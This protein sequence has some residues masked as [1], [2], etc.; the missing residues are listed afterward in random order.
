MI[1]IGTDFQGW[2]INAM[3]LREILKQ[4]GFKDEDGKMSIESK[5]PLLDSYPCILTDDGMGYGVDPQYV[6]EADTDIYDTQVKTLELVKND[7]SEL[8]YDEEVKTKTIKVFNVFRDVPENK[9]E[10]DN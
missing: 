8:G 10:N 3:T 5:N 6:T 7:D 4:I 2:P 1:R 9:T